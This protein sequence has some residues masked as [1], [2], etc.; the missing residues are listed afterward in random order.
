MTEKPA[1][2]LRHFDRSG[3]E[4]RNLTPLMTEKLP[5]PS[6]ISTEAKRSGEISLHHGTGSIGVGDLSTQSFIEAVSL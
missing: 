1:R 3:A 4:W 2:A 6:V 5:V